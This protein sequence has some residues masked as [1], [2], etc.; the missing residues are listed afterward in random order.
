[1]IGDAE[2][3]QLKK[4]NLVIYRYLQRNSEARINQFILAAQLHIA[5]HNGKYPPAKGG[6]FGTM[7][8]HDVISNVA[9]MQLG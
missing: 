5:C 6:N 3:A 1:V 9:D 8:K 7:I 4:F 2:A